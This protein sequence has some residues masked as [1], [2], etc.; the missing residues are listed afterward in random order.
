MKN[1]YTELTEEYQHLKAIYGVHSRSWS[2]IHENFSPYMFCKENRKSLIAEYLT[3]EEFVRRCNEYKVDVPRYFGID[4]FLRE[5][6][7]A[8]YS[9]L[10]NI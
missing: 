4:I 3:W 10:T 9:C 5:Y 1:I 8:V 2:E 7:D 6:K